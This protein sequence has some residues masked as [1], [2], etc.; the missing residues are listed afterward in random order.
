MEN[1]NASPIGLRCGLCVPGENTYKCVS[2]AFSTT[3]I[4][5]L[6]E[7]SLQEHGETLTLPKLKA[8]AALRSTRPSAE[9]SDEN[10]P[11]DPECTGKTAHTGLKVSAGAAETRNRQ[12]K[13]DLFTQK[14]AV[15]NSNNIYSF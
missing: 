13:G 2:C 4:S 3:T 11:L 15:L 5:Q 9:H 8:G 1:C 7:H 12:N 6:K 10:T 14:S